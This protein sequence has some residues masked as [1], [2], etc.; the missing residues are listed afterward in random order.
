[1]EKQKADLTIGFLFSSCALRRANPLLQFAVNS[2]TAKIG[3]VLL[4]LQTLGVRLSVLRR[5]VTRGWLALFAGFCAFESD[6][7]DFALFRHD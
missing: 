2:V 4:F 3:I 1:M 6:D 7:S 5:C